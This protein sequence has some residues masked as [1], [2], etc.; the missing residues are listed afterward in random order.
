VCVY[1]GSVCQLLLLMESET[2]CE[3]FAGAFCRVLCSCV[4]QMLGL[5][6]VTAKSS[7]VHIFMLCWWL[8][9]P[10]TPCPCRS[11]GV[12]QGFEGPVVAHVT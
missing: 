2:A 5:G 1:V 4:V 10:A 12:F 7:F 3:G 9:R 6:P 11:P 8:C